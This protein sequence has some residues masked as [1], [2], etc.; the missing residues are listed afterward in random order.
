MFTPYRLEGNPA[1]PVVISDSTGFV[2]L[3]PIPLTPSLGGLAE[4]TLDIDMAIDTEGELLCNSIDV[5]VTD[6]S[7]QDG[8][9]VVEGGAAPLDAGAGP[10]P[11]PFVVN[12]T[13]VCD[14]SVD[15]FVVIRPT[16]SVSLGFV[17]YDLFGYELPPIPLPEYDETLE[18]GPIPLEFVRPEPEPEPETTGDPTDTSDPSDSDTSDPSAGTDSGDTS[19]SDSNSD[20]DSNSDTATDGDSMDASAGG[21]DAGGQDSFGTDGGTDSDGVGDEGCGC[22]S[23]DAPAAPA[24]LWIA[25][26]LGLAGRR[27]RS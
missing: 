8:S 16:L 21:D 1:R 11:D 13:L 17:D 3:L 5:A 19:N 7:A 15:V 2:T 12:A 27:R 9:I 23:T 4:G 14:L 25:L 6:P 22:R 26:G 10:L 18:M 20:G 24:L